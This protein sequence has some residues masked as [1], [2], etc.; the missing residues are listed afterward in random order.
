MP[1]DPNNLQKI[2][3]RLHGNRGVTGRWPA[4]AHVTGKWPETTICASAR[5]GS[6]REN[7][8]DIRRRSTNKRAE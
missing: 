2:L 3:W 8:I 6:A 7:L 5:N 4:T 1:P